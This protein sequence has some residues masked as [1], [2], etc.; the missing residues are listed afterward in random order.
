MIFS[1]KRS[2]LLL[3]ALL[4]SVQ[5]CKADA[6]DGV[7]PFSFGVT[8]APV[9]DISGGLQ[10]N[11]TMVGPG[12]TEVALSYGVEVT[13]D[14]R[15]F[16]T[17]SGETFV[18]IGENDFVAAAYSVKGRIRVIGET[19]HATLVVRLRGQD[20]IA[21]VLTTFSISAVYEL[22]VSAETGT[23][24]GGARGTAN[25]GRLG[26]TKISSTPVS[27]ALPP[28]SGGDWTLQLTIVP[29]NHLAG[30]ALVILPNG[31]TFQAHLS[32]RFVDD[33]STVKVTGFAEG[34]GNSVTIVFN[35][36][37]EVLF[38]RGRILGQLVL[39]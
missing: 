31:R 30:T 26:K 17:G 28:S 33:Q 4:G 39:Q 5:F 20:V 15:G 11:Q 1:T 18:Q 35:T 9:F 36:D 14:A 16:F 34:R 8:N 19:T 10:L 32:G 23:L 13:Q 12:G 21:G 24:E 6:P 25:F 37:L 38:L 3:A 29:L 27:V 7:L 22:D 2:L